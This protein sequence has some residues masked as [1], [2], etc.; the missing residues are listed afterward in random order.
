MEPV[1]LKDLKCRV[2]SQVLVLDLSSGCKKVPVTMNP[3]T[4]N[5]SR[6]Q[7]TVTTTALIK[8]FL[9]I[10]KKVFAKYHGPKYLENHTFASIIT[11]IATNS[12]ESD[13]MYITGSYVY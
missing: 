11:Q 1:V 7:H 9:M 6:L 8:L 3:V 2:Y 5:K 10:R 13:N 12:A 4:M